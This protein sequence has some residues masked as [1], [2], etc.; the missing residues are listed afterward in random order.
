[1]KI[2]VRT[3]APSGTFFRAGRAWTK[4]GTVLE[5]G[6]LTR[7]TWAILEAEPMIHIGPAPDDAELAAA[8]ADDLKAL[9]R[10][11]IAGLGDESFGQ[12]GVPLLDA[13]RKELPEGSP[14]V[15]RKLVSDIWAEL[16]AD[17]AGS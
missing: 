13:V 4:A 2:L 17:A 11:A 7:Q 3:T 9:V 10:K 8:S 5:Q 6:D 12:D 1:M 15:T 14:A 16:K